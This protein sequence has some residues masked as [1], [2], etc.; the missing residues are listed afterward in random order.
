MTVG[1]ERSDG[2]LAPHDLGDGVVVL[3]DA[4]DPTT[5]CRTM[6]GA[7]LTLWQDGS[8]GD[9]TGARLIDLARDLEATDTQWLEQHLRGR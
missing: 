6:G 2:A 1:S 3:G 5:I 8:R 9:W 7:K 4:T